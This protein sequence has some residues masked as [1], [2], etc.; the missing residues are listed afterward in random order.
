MQKRKRYWHV[1]YPPQ[2]IKKAIELLYLNEIEHEYSKLFQIGHKDEDLYFDSEDEFYSQ[3]RTEITDAQV[4]LHLKEKNNKNYLFLNIE[5]STLRTIV[6]FECNDRGRIEKLFEI[7]ESNYSKYRLSED[8]LQKELKQNVK[9]FIGHGHKKEWRD[10]KDHLQD[11]HGYKVI[12]YEIGVRAGYT[13][14]EVLED[15]ISESTIAFLVMTGDDRDDKGNLKAREN[16]IHE[17]GLFQGKLGFKKSIVLLEEGCNEFS[18]IH[19]IQQLR[20]SKGN[21][22]EIFGDVIAIIN[23]EFELKSKE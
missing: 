14:T 17:T 5:F 7:F 15:M 21:I 1:K 9:I 18:N 20:F 19:G 11:K 23:R 22:S 2:I 13:I 3:Y 8:D 16:V 12:C 4:K 10:L 6:S